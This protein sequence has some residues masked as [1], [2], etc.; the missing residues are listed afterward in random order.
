VRV[1]PEELSRIK[2]E[3]MGRG[4]PYAGGDLDGATMDCDYALIDA[5]FT[6]PQ[7]ERTGD[8]AEL[9]RYTSRPELSSTTEGEAV[10]RLEEAWIESASFSE[11]A[12]SI[13]IHGGVLALDFV[14]WWANNHYCT[15]R[16]EVDLRNKEQ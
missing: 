5:G 6:G 2:A 1:E 8:P 10:A 12:H 16:I 13:S 7:I 15:G 11:E 9:V 3:I 4:R 14:T